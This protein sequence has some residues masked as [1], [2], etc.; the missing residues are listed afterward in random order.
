MILKG[1]TRCDNDN[2]RALLEDAQSHETINVII[3]KGGGNCEWIAYDENLNNTW[4]IAFV[5]TNKSDIND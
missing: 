2:Y 5:G 1:L 3:T 4:E